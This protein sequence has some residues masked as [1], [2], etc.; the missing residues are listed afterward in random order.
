MQRVAVGAFQLVDVYAGC[1]GQAAVMADEH[2]KRLFGRKRQNK[3]KTFL[4]NIHST[5]YLF[6]LPL[7][8]TS[9]AV[10][11]LISDTNKMNKRAEY[12]SMNVLPSSHDNCCNIAQPSPMNNL[13]KSLNRRLCLCVCVLGYLAHR[14]AV[15]EAWFGESD[16][17]AR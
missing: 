13:G 1:C 17:F 4:C 9:I 16:D 7:C 3:I 8:K 11:S 6:V 10:Q 2:V 14:T 5:L 12:E 15:G